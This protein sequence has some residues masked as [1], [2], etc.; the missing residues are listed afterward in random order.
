MEHYTMNPALIPT[1]PGHFETDDFVFFWSGPFSNWYKSNFTIPTGLVKG[2]YTSSEQA[3]MIAKARMFGD[4]TA[5]CEIMATNNPRRQKEIGRSVKGFDAVRWQSEC[6]PI[7]TDV[8]VHKFDQ[9]DDLFKILMD[10]NDKIIVEASPFDDV[11]GIK[12]GVD[13]VDILDQTKWQG[14]NYLGICLMNARERLK[15]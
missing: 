11:W 6:V 12:M 7:I 5:A 13:H 10:T 8:L 2:D 1:V 15:G 3:M 14:K 4:I 9:N